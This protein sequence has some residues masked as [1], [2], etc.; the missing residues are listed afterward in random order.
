MGRTARERLAKLLDDA[1]APGAFSAQI[2]AP[3][4]ALQVEVDGVGVVQAPV[5]APVIPVRFPADE[6]LAAAMRALPVM[7]LARALADWVGD[8]AMGFRARPYQARA[9]RGYCE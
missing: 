1:E 8:N 2:L 3:A 6:E 9:I 5:R 7:R 4:D